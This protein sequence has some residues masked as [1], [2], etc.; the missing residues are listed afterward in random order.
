MPDILSNYGNSNTPQNQRKKADFAA[1]LHAMNY[2]ID[3]LRQKLD[4]S[5]DLEL[6][7]KSEYRKTAAFK[8]LPEDQFNT[9]YNGVKTAFNL[10]E[11][12]K[13]MNLSNPFVK[14]LFDTPY[15]RE[16]QRTDPRVKIG[17]NINQQFDLNPFG[18]SQGMAFGDQFHQATS[19]EEAAQLNTKIKDSKTGQ[20]I[21]LGEPVGNLGTYI[22]YLPRGLMI[23]TDSNG[24]PKLDNLGRPYYETIDGRDTTG[25]EHLIAKA[26]NFLTQEGSF[27]NAIDP[28]DSDQIE[29]NTARSII[30]NTLKVGSLFVPYLRTSVLGATALL[31]MGTMFSEAWKS[32][33]AL[34]NKLSGGDYKPD[35]DVERRANEI[36]NITKS[37]TWGSQTEEE[38][39]DPWSLASLSN[40][41]ADGVSQIKTQRFIAQAPIFARAV[42]DPKFRRA[43]EAGDKSAEAY[44]NAAKNLAR[45][46]MTGQ[47]AMEVGEAFERAGL[48]KETKDLAMGAAAIAFGALYQAAP[49]SWMLD[50]VGVNAVQRATKKV[51]EKEVNDLASSL[52]VESAKKTLTE[53]E[54]KSI[55]AKGLAKIQEKV[56][57][58]L[59]TTNF[60]ETL[61]GSANEALEES[62]E[63]VIGEALK[64]GFQ[65]LSK[66]NLIKSDKEALKKL[67]PFG[68]NFLEDLAL[69]AVAGGMSGG[70]FGLAQDFQLRKRARDINSLADISQNGY[71]EYALNELEKLR[72]LGKRGNG[73]VSDKLSTEIERIENG[74]PIY[75]PM[76][77]DTTLISQNDYVINTVKQQ[78]L[79]THFALQAIGADKE[80]LEEKLKN[81]DELFKSVYAEAKNSSLLEDAKQ[82]SKQLVATLSEIDELKKEAEIK[83]ANQTGD[84]AIDDELKLKLAPLEK[85]AEQLKQRFDEIAKVGKEK[86]ELAEEYLLETLYKANPFAWAG[87]DI[88]SKEDFVKDKVGEELQRAE[89]EWQEYRLFKRNNDIK[90]AYK[91]A[92]SIFE[93]SEFFKKIKDSSTDL[94]NLL[95]NEQVENLLYTLSSTENKDERN[96]IIENIKQIFDLEEYKPTK[97]VLDMLKQSYSVE[98]PLIKMERVFDEESPFDSKEVTKKIQLKN[99]DSN[100]YKQQ[101]S[102]ELKDVMPFFEGEIGYTSF[103]VPQINEMLESPTFDDYLQKL[104][105]KDEETQEE[106]PLGRIRETWLDYYSKYGYIEEAEPYITENL[107]RVYDL[108]KKLENN[109]LIQLEKILEQ[110]G[111]KDPKNIIPKI[112][113]DDVEKIIDDN[114]EL[115]LE[116][117][118]GY[119]D[120]NPEDESSI[121]KQLKNAINKVTKIKS[122]IQIP[123]R[124]NVL[125]NRA[126]KLN[127]DKFANPEENF[128]FKTPQHAFYFESYLSKLLAKLDFLLDK[129]KENK[130]G[131]VKL[132][133]VGFL[134]GLSNIIKNILDSNRIAYEQVAFTPDLLKYV[135]ADEEEILRSE[136]LEEDTSKL[137]GILIQLSELLKKPEYQNR[138]LETRPQ[139][140]KVDVPDLRD[141]SKSYVFFEEALR[142]GDF[143]E[144][145]QLYQKVKETIGEK[146][147]I[148]PTVE[149]EFIIFQVF[150]L[151]QAAENGKL[152]AIAPKDNQTKLDFFN[153]IFIDG[154]P[155]IGK[156]DVIIRYLIELLKEKEGIEINVTSRNDS[157][158]KDVLGSKFDPEF[159]KTFS[160]LGFDPHRNIE[161][162]LESGRDDYFY[163]VYPHQP[164]PS[165]TSEND[166]RLKKVYFIDEATH[167][168]TPLIEQMS[169]EDNAVFVFFGDTTQD[170]T[171]ETLTYNDP[172]GKE[173]K[174]TEPFFQ[175][176]NGMERVPRIT[177][178]LRNSTENY[179]KNAAKLEQLIKKLYGSDY[180]E[181]QKVYNEFKSDAK[182]RLEFFY[183]ESS[184]GSLKEGVKISDNPLEEL[185][186]IML[187]LDAVDSNQSIVVISD[188]PREA[189]YP[190]NVKILT[191]NSIQGQE[192]DYVIIDNI[193]LS[194]DPLEKARK[195]N[196]LLSRFK[197]GMIVPSELTKEYPMITYKKEGEI[198]KF[199]FFTP[200]V[201]DELVR[202]SLGITKNVRGLEKEEE[203]EKE[204]EEKKEDQETTSVSSSFP[205]PII[206]G[207]EQEN[208]VERQE[209][210]QKPVIPIERIEKY[211]E[212]EYEEEYETQKEKPKGK[213]EDI[214]FEPNKEDE[215]KI[216]SDEPIVLE[217]KT[218][219]Y[220]AFPNTVFS[221]VTSSG[222]V[223]EG[224]IGK[225]QLINDLRNLTEEEFNQKYPNV[226]FEIHSESG[227]TVI[228]FKSNETLQPFIYLPDKKFLNYT[229]EQKTLTFQQLKDIVKSSSIY[230][231]KSGNPVTLKLN[232]AKINS[233]QF[234][235]ATSPAIIVNVSPLVVS[236]II[237]EIS[238]R[239]AYKSLVDNKVKEKVFKDVIGLQGKTIVFFSTDPK[240]VELIDALNKD[241]I[242]DSPSLF[243]QYTERLFYKYIEHSLQHHLNIP[244][245]FNITIG[246]VKKQTN[247]TLYDYVKNTIEKLKNK[248]IESLPRLSRSE[249]RR[250]GTL[251]FAYMKKITELY[252][253]P[254]EDALF[255]SLVNWKYGEG[256]YF[257]YTE[258]GKI[259]VR[260]ERKS[261]LELL[262]G[263]GYEGPSSTNPRGTFYQVRVVQKKDE[264]GNPIVEKKNLKNKVVEVPEVE[265]ER[266][267]LKDGELPEKL[268][269]YTQ[270]V[271]NPFNE[272]FEF[273]YEEIKEAGSSEIKQYSVLEALAGI[274]PTLKL[275][276]ENSPIKELEALSKK[277][278]T[279][280]SPSDKL[281]KFVFEYNLES[282]IPYYKIDSSFDTYAMRVKEQPDFLVNYTEKGI[283]PV[284]EIPLD[285][286]SSI[287]GLK[288]AKLLVK[289]K[290]KKEQEVVKKQ[291]TTT[292]EEKPTIEP[293][294]T[295]TSTPIPNFSTDGDTPLPLTSK[296]V[297]AL[298]P[299]ADLPE[300]WSLSHGMQESIISTGYK[301]DLNG[302]LTPN[303]SALDKNHV[304]SIIYGN[305]REVL[306]YEGIRFIKDEILRPIYYY[307]H[308]TGEV[309]PDVYTE[310]GVIKF[311]QNIERLLESKKLALKQ[312][313]K[314]EDATDEA[315]YMKIQELKNN[316]IINNNIRRILGEYLTIENL[317]HILSF[318]FYED[319]SNVLK[320]KLTR[321]Q[322]GTISKIFV[323]QNV[324]PDFTYFQESSDRGGLE[325]SSSFIRSL[326]QRLPRIKIKEVN[327]PEGKKVEFYTDMR[328]KSSYKEISK[329]LNDIMYDQEEELLDETGNIDPKKIK[330]EYEK[331]IQNNPS[332]YNKEAI[333]N[334]YILFFNESFK[335]S[336]P[337]P[338]IVSGENIYSLYQAVKVAELEGI[339]TGNLAKAMALN[340]V[341]TAF[342]IFSKIKWNEII[343][344]DD[345]N[346]VETTKQQNKNFTELYQV[347]L[348]SRE[349]SDFKDALLKVFPADVV[350]FLFNQ[351]NNVIENAKKKYKDLK[352]QDILLV[353][354]TIDKILQTSSLKPI[355]TTVK[356]VNGDSIS[357]TSNRNISRRL[358]TYV[359]RTQSNYEPF[360]NRKCV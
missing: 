197:K 238:E 355:T 87:F 160:E 341:K 112:K 307:D 276:E 244:K 320:V 259:V 202:F 142:R 216:S 177:L 109:E 118:K 220:F 217:G 314:L 84:K 139:R 181:V 7:D 26:D 254:M 227:K 335:N 326:I 8:D 148:V 234:G 340:N 158:V 199:V 161:V 44:V 21:D 279:P 19:V 67:D 16:L 270:K 229:V 203:K 232:E 122:T 162:P 29:K 324:V 317:H 22:N 310:E 342:N 245:T 130:E 70:V 102:E 20:W 266:I 252:D 251:L 61:K 59:S 316:A 155:G 113:L 175:Y 242:Y 200:E 159:V 298:A 201:L 293:E 78:L 325:S 108:L 332:K 352:N 77:S 246:F 328:S 167:L 116:N 104:K 83:K 319:V 286:L 124:I 360:K 351:K 309:L 72:D 156:T 273:K 219:L 264:N 223:L 147:K 1:S 305:N 327:T 315:F 295:V 63:V 89:K 143:R 46:Y 92:K 41:L 64:K 111:K 170:G 168:T 198:T 169:K 258:G 253:N 272:I 239:T 93:E 287:L 121:T 357:V 358:H 81:A 163:P 196:T 86:S 334:L 11:Q 69:S 115:Y 140:T 55:I 74:V 278:I 300:N 71:T 354:T 345:I 101:L 263:F 6:K 53:A 290:E 247:L 68:E 171:S 105:E 99:V 114:Y 206:L 191:S 192:F 127:K 321:N 240:I 125:I 262:F 186:K 212:A 291:A 107:R 269:P 230:N 62:T 79:S 172:S 76:S 73:L 141:Y 190:Q 129:L 132:I 312:I 151:I 285:Q 13:D 221:V 32:F 280:N 5:V 235:V 145:L 166:K 275:V 228:M 281:L 75:K 347:L 173:V 336:K 194:E 54:K 249:L 48:D 243:D 268:K 134:K 306:E 218:F 283:Y 344:I 349:S 348:N 85:R 3:L 304:A 35:E 38:Q 356:N 188:K 184:N 47:A 343:S 179:D 27:L 12:N 215:G 123:Y 204:E 289:P 303:T 43:L 131:D 296:D 94:N 323:P 58:F 274:D 176:T 40:I 338:V 182:N 2:D 154:R 137:Y 106:Y 248:Q 189:N 318:N 65:F 146:N 331:I 80:G 267:P 50:G 353:A 165:L 37:L 261:A 82:I 15:T 128:T 96:R 23:A 193:E 346:I 231:R 302:N 233:S 178:S 209:V 330:Q 120:N 297:G 250:F 359:K 257:E 97:E 205:K 288:E 51:I 224:V 237:E 284:L 33:S 164:K 30:K 36:A 226:S 282:A 236:N 126:K 308:K 208:S 45:V 103:G 213:A 18:I 24:M 157:F 100:S 214:L 49:F 256:L 133:R 271:V 329:W 180:E 211:E 260:D 333:V 207:L 311:N 60:A 152:A 42:A 313:L 117:P 10:F 185:Q 110:K 34:G 98:I 57:N 174:I 52:A 299:T 138:T 350:E 9:W 187:S 4:P 150:S 294:A 277:T 225:N 195:L 135:S 17:A 210:E 66:N 292:Q 25:K 241:S 144:F 90:R 88:K 255:Q 31:N 39:Q 153:S 91:E 95:L 119:R 14:T 301:A 183:T 222:E 337:E 265:F 136:K 28:F 56:R 339:Q 322:D 149:Q